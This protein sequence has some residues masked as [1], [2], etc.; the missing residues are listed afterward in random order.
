MTAPPTRPGTRD[1]RGS[2][3]TRE[4]RNGRGRHWA[5]AAAALALGLLTQLGVVPLAPAGAADLPGG[6]RVYTIAM[7]DGKP[8]ALAVR[9]AI[10]EFST[11]GTVTERYWAWRQDGI[12][13]RTNTRWTKPSSGYTTTGC[14]YTCPIRTPVGFQKTAHPHVF[15]GRWSMESQSVLAITWSPTYPVERWQLNTSQPGLVGARLLSARGKAYGWGVG[16]HAPADRGVNLGSVYASSWISGPFAENVYSPTTQTSWIGWSAQDYTL[17][18]GGTC[19]QSKTMT[20]SDRSKWYHSYFAA[21]PTA[22]GRKV[23]WNNQTGAVQRLESPNTVCISTSGGGHTN[24]LLQVLDDRGRFVGFVGVEASLNQ[25]KHGQAVV[26][27]Y[28]ML[29]PS[30]LPVIGAS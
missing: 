23:Y 22:D 12:S 19:M 26:A 28:T 21:N 11:N 27:A 5:G 29:T 13:G 7:M 14:R 25:R 10:Y 2:W 9:L 30:L 18:T 6:R 3:E 17:C 1:T 20:G 15:T 4:T 16:S 24:A 8:Q